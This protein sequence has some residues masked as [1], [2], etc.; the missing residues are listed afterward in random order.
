MSKQH[1][2]NWL[3]FIVL[4]GLISWLVAVDMGRSGTLYQN[5]TKTAYRG[6]KC[7]Y[8]CD[9]FSELLEYTK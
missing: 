5:D 3:V 8:N 1:I 6:L 2:L 9:N 7:V 4:V